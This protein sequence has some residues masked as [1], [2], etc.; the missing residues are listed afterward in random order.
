MCEPDCAAA[1]GGGDD[2]SQLDLDNFDDYN[3]YDTCAA[4][5]RSQF[6]DHRVWFGDELW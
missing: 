3:L 4:D 2:D 1:R 6:V 5:N